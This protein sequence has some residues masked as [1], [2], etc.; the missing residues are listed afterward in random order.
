MTPPK[1]ESLSYSP[2][3]VD[4]TDGAQSVTVTVR[5]TDSG[6]A[7]GGY[8][9]FRNVINEQN[10]DTALG[11]FSLTAGTAQDGTWQ[12]TIT[13]PAGAPPGS[14]QYI[15]HLEDTSSNSIAFGNEFYSQ[16]L[17]PMA[18]GSLTVTD[19]PTPE[20]TAT[21]SPTIEPTASPTS[22]PTV[23]PSP[24]PTAS[25]SPEPTASPSPEPTASPVARAV[26][27]PVTRAVREPVARAVPRARRPSRPRARRPSRPPA[28]RPSR[29]PRRAAPGRPS[30]PPQPVT[31][32]VRQ[33]KS[34]TAADRAARA[35]R[36]PTRRRRSLSPRA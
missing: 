5:I 1:L 30:R 34:V 11:Y 16:N 35:H 25:P 32:A 27:E 2:A 20:P 4:V 6:G 24:E 18:P 3:S 26:R 12:T 28:R 22:S 14:W 21:A 13:V 9:Y 8:L 23:S 29:L 15:G 7:A 10:H 31:P 36:R 17:P 19:G 33:P